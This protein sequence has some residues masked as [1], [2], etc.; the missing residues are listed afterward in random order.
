MTLRRKNLELQRQL[1]DALLPL[2]ERRAQWQPALNLF[3]MNWMEEA[4]YAKRL[5]MSAAQST[6]A[7]R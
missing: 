5:H 2:A 3:A 7:V 4:D 6:D 1:V